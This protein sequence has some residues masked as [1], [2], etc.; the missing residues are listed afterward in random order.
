MNISQLEKKIFFIF[1]SFIVLLGVFLA[2]F[3][4]GLRDY[5]AGEQNLYG[6]LKK[7]ADI[8]AK[9]DSLDRQEYQEHA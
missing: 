7:D 8:F 3:S 9:K 5:F 1:I 2:A 6:G 4:L